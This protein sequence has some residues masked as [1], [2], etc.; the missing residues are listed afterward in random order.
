[1]NIRFISFWPI[2][3]FL[4]VIISLVSCDVP[5]GRSEKENTEPVSTFTLL[6]KAVSPR[7]MADQETVTVAVSVDDEFGNS[8]DKKN[9][10]KGTDAWF[11]HLNL[12]ISGYVNVKIEAQDS[13]GVARYSWSGRKQ[14]FGNNSDIIEAQMMPLLESTSSWDTSKGLPNNKVKSIVASESALW[15]GTEKGIVVTSDGGNFWG[16]PLLNSE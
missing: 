11:G 8:L 12:S 9:L 1:M 6:V 15:V 14:L 4:G 13:N 10:T 5:V 7:F 3:G 2:L 16:S